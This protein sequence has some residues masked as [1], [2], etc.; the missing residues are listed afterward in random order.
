M[1]KYTVILWKAP[2]VEGAEEAAALLEP[3]HER[4]DDSAFQP[5]ADI[6]A[7][8]NALRDRFPDA[9]WEEEQTDRLLVLHIPGDVDFVIG[10][11]FELAREHELVLYD[12]QGQDVE[13]PG[14]LPAA[15]RT[16]VKM[17]WSEHL[18][19]GSLFGFVGLAG[20]LVFWL[21]WRIDVPVLDWL[22]MIVGGFF[23]TM[24]PFW[25]FIVMS[26]PKDESR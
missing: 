9:P 3:Y 2:L 1:S 21:G 6:A 15:P 13:L 22:L 4:E 16:P 12:P 11:I 24:F 20:A 23:F 19:A 7:V 14:D 17:S 25:L 5:S 26:A 10:T 8:S 18:K